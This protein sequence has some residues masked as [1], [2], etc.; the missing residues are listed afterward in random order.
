MNSKKI[1]NLLRLRV[2]DNISAM[3]SY[4][5]R[6]LTC[7][8]ANAELVEWYG[9]PKEEMIDKIKLQDLL[10]PLYE[11]V[12]HPLEGVLR[13]EAQTFQRELPMPDGSVRHTLINYYPD[14]MDGVVLGFFKHVVDVTE[15]KL[16]EQELV[17]QNEKIN[18]QN[19]RLLNFSNIVSHNLKSYSLNLSSILALYQ[20]ATTEEER[21]RLF[22]FLQRISKGFT[23]TV[24]HLNEIV[25]SQNIAALPPV[26][27][28]LHEYIEATKQTLLIQIS[29][30]GAVVL[31]QVPNDIVLM[32]NPTYMESILLNL[33]T[34]ALKYRKET[35]AP[36]IELRCI[37]QE[38]KTIFSIK[39][40]GRGINLSKHGEDVFKMYK[41]F[42]GNS[43]AE[44]VGLYI[45]K[46][47][48][49]T[50]GGEITVE[51]EEG[52]GTTFSLTFGV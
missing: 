44:G 12:L 32:A 40:N 42:H 26:P 21:S 36:I 46:Y 41:T 13:G 43:D 4:W 28:N 50:M 24:N 37:Q 5:D 31:N 19:N 3:V 33:M 45:T 49:Q 22:H 30:V 9:K 15:L 8:F 14:I 35:E 52:V 48:V 11:N 16:L 38:G 51:S 17:S 2:P 34:N 7:K 23:T 6:D 18:E 1:E 47:Q 27:V 20:E 10:G 39:D 29:S 25:Q